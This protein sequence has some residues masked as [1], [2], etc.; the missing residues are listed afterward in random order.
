MDVS[1]VGLIKAIATAIPGTAANRAEKA[2][3]DA[4]DYAEQAQLASI[5]AKVEDHKLIISAE[6][7]E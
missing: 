2:A 6:V 3:Q 4:Q 5:G 1:M 7:S